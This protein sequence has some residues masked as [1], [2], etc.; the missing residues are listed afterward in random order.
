M[1]CCLQHRNECGLSELLI[2]IAALAED[3]NEAVRNSARESLV[4]VAHF[5]EDALSVMQQLLDSFMFDT[6]CKRLVSQ[7]VAKL[8]RDGLV[9]LPSVS[10][11]DAMR[12]AARPSEQPAQ[13]SQAPPQATGG[14]SVYSAVSQKMWESQP[15]VDLPRDDIHSKTFSFDKEQ[16]QEKPK[17]GRLGPKPPERKGASP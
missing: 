4:V 13:P 2:N 7:T 10:F 1:M 15:K 14:R 8:G 9:E 12:T 16:T 3:A 6:I 11:E 17:V 5:N